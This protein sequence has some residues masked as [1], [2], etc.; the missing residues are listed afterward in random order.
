MKEE[1]E[2]KKEEDEEDEKKINSTVDRNDASLACDDSNE[3]VTPIANSNAFG[4]A[5][6][7]DDDSKDAKIVKEICEK[8]LL[9]VENAE[10]IHFFN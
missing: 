10:G 7:N 6:K 9:T 1:N 3:K 4:C 5:G 8:I 2:E